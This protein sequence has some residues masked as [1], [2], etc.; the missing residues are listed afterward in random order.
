LSIKILVTSLSF[1]KIVKEPVRLL[2]SK[3]YELLWTELGRPLTDKELSERVKGVDG[4]IIGSDKVGKYTLSSADKLK[5]IARY[6]VG[7]DNVDLEEATD[8]GVVVTNTPG[9]N[10][11]AVADLT[12]GLIL[13]LARSIPQADKNVKE[14][15]WKRFFGYSVWGKTLGIIGMG[16]IGL[17]VVKRGIGFNMDV[18]Y[19]DIR[20]NN[21]ADEAGAKKV[22]LDFLLRNSDFITLHLPSTPHTRNF[23][24][25][26]ELSK[27]KKSSF[28]INT[29]R[30]GIV[31]EVA[32]YRWLKDK[33][34][35]G[36]ALDVYSKEP[37]SNLPLLSLDNIITTPHIGA[38]TYEALYNM[39]M[40]AAKSVVDVIEGRY[41]EYL[42]NPEVYKKRV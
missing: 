17:A 19:F 2:E 4:L 32:L 30:G 21:Q 11:D 33:K 42:V 38:Y 31:D 29:A 37:P 40:M 39:G 25:E 16:N 10:L 22:E 24:G 34:I 28:L 12:F 41:P 15:G 18:L 5:V 6:G 14:G 35:A 20:R 9:A 23:I 26:R 36:A 7:I 3:G 27:M 1:G 13:S 8:K